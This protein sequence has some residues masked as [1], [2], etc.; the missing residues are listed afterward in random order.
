MSVL[1]T[2]LGVFTGV[3]AYH[4]Y[5]THPRN[6][7]KFVQGETLSELL[8]WKWARSDWSKRVK[9]SEEGK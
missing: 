5:E 9:T 3:L 6:M 8:R 7:G 4:L 2:F 1:D